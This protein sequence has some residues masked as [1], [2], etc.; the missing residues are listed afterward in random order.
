[1]KISIKKLE[2]AT[3]YKIKRNFL[4]IGFDIATRTGV[5]E[6]LTTD[7]NVEFNWTFFEFDS[8]NK[9]LL[10]KNM[11]YAF[12][13]VLN[14]QDFAVVEDTFV[15]LNPN[16][17]LMLTRFGAF[18]IVK[19]IENRIPWDLIRASPARSR[20]NI[21]YGKFG[22]GKSKQSVAYWLETQLNIKLDDND[23]SDAIV[24]S[25]LGLCEGMDFA[26]KLRPKKKRRKVRAVSKS[27]ASNF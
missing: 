19:C 18:A 13:R 15:G 2:K 20:L 7:K 22:K 21:D 3:G 27:R 9:K 26:P 10:Y 23:I 17:S 6:L 8:S 24:L 25:I 5:C 14:K 1:M 16:A 12:D 11:L 4:S